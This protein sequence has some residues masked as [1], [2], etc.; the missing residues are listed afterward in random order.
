MP[1]SINSSVSDT[2]RW[3]KTNTRFVRG[4]TDPATVLGALL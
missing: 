2:V 4:T 3:E 1:G